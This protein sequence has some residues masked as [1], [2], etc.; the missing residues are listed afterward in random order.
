MDHPLVDGN[1]RLA[2]LMLY[3]FIK[4]NGCVLKE[5][6]KLYDLAIL[7]AENKIDKEGV[8]KWLRKRLRRKRKR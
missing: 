5:K 8:M 2:S 3:Y 4:K 1:K 6:N 7:V